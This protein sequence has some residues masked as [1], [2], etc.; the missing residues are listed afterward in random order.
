M[1]YYSVVVGWCVGFLLGVGCSLAVL[2]S[3]YRGG[4][5]RAVGDGLKEPQPE[6]YRDAVAKA[7]AAQAAKDSRE[8]ARVP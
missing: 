6:A 8:T 1:I 7:K 4:Y 5:R 3:I 2:Y